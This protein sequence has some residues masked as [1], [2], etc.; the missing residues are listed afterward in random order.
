MHRT[1]LRLPGSPA[2]N[3][4]RK[5]RDAAIKSE[6]FREVLRQQ[7]AQDDKLRELSSIKSVNG[8]RSCRL[9]S[10]THEN[11]YRR[12]SFFSGAQSLS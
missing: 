2:W 1:K 3:F 5:S 9:H 12:K 4:W 11:S 8:V 7:K 6:T 10:G